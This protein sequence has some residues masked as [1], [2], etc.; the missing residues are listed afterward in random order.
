MDTLLCYLPMSKQLEHSESK[1]PIF[2]TFLTLIAF[3]SSFS[4]IPPLITTIADEMAVNYASFGYIIMFQAVSF[5][6]AAIIG[7]WICERHN[8]NSRALVVVGLLIVGLTLLLGSALTRVTWFIIWAI[9]LGFGGGLIE[10]FASILVTQ[11]DKPHSSKLMNLAQVFFCIGAISAS[12]IVAVMLYLGISWRYIFILFGLFILFILCVFFFLT[13]KG[14]EDA[15]RFAQKANKFST[16]LLKDSLF[17]LLAAVL[18][19]YVTFESVIACW[20]SVYFEKR[21][22]VPVHSAALRLSI[23]WIGLVVGRLAIILVPRR[24]TIWPAMFTGIL[25]MCIGAVLASLTLSPLWATVFVFLSG[26]GAGPLWPTTV[27]ICHSARQR[28][29]FTSYVIAVA[30]FGVVLGSGLG[31]VIFR[32]LDSSLFFPSVALGSI[33]LLVLSFLSYQKYSKTHIIE[34]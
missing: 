2:G 5:F 32:Y 23:Y 16:L 6:L 14:S 11:K 29:K 19:I 24:F 18:L 20:V 3:G 7:G 31:S 17:F 1:L 25:I 9:P 27:A 8:I 26:F 28:P 33:I 10:T 30:A 15:V 34:E 22:S 12:P 21:L 4:L 13:R